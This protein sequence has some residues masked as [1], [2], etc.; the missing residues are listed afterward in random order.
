M[1]A[2][3]TALKHTPL[4][5]WHS[6]N[7]GRMVDFAGWSMPVQ[8]QSVIQEHHQTRN[9]VGVFD[10]SHMGRFFFYGTNVGQWI[11]GLMTRRIAGVEVGK[12]RYSL[13][14]NEDG[15]VLD[16]VLVYHL[17]CHPEDGSAF[18][19]SEANG[20]SFYMVVVNA[21]NREKL[22]G[23]FQSHI[24]KDSDIRLEDR[25]EE[26]AMIAVQGPEANGIVAAM[27][28]LDPESLAYYG[29]AVAKLDDQWTI[30]SRTGY[31]GEDGCELIL[32]ASVAENLWGRIIEKAHAAGGGAS[33]L[34][35]RDTLR[36]EAGMPLYEHELSEEINAASTGLN[37]AINT[38]D[39]SFCGDV[40]ISKSK[41][42]AT[43]NVRV[44]LELEG[45]RPAREGCPVRVDGTQVGVLTSGT[46]SPTLEKPIAMAYLSPKFSTVGTKVDVDIRGKTH[47]ATV[48]AL[49]FY[50]RPK[51]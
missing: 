26:T 47:A 48:V 21:G 17:N 36:L 38:K 16:D 32:D 14:T 50:K 33:G 24:P 51:S 6:N 11:D 45:R 28:T 7:G 40:A 15:M 8:Y 34:A 2:D 37:F 49:P 19:P 29:G 39:R 3:N 13:V 30:V 4:S 44:G 46:L 20:T 22:A 12:I 23:W 18:L 5:N 25:T 10:V 31:T 43:D 35:A 1:S 42:A 41:E 27:A 9:A